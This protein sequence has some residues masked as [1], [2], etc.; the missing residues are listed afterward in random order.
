MAA[1]EGPTTPNPG[2]KS[3]YPVPAATPPRALEVDVC[4]YGGTPGGVAAAVQAR[5][6]GKTVALTVF[7]R[8]VD[9]L[10]SAGLKAVDFGKAESIGGIAAE[11]LRAGERP[12]S[13]SS[14]NDRWAEFRPSQAETTFR[15]LLAD[16]WPFGDAAGGVDGLRPGTGPPPRLTDPDPPKG[17]DPDRFVRAVDAQLRH[18]TLVICG[19]FRPN[20]VIA[21]ALPNGNGT[22]NLVIMRVFDASN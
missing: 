17:M 18:Q 10:T 8:H 20:E 19:E 1:A 2:L 4:V 22:E 6:M 13:K 21:V 7:R 11:F 14:E 5:R 16:T 3:Y 9:G 12:G 15:A